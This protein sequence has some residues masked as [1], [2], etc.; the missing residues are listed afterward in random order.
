[1]NSRTAVGQVVLERAVADGEGARGTVN[2]AAQTGAAGRTVGTHGLVA[3]KYAV[4]EGH[5]P[6]LVVEAAAKGAACVGAAEG[7]II[8][9][10]AEGDGEGRARQV[11]NASAPAGG[12]DSL[13]H[14]A[15]QGILREGEVARVE[16]AG[17]IGGPTVGE[18]QTGDS[19][20][21][22]AANGKDSAGRVAADR[23]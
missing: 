11:L 15:N 9:E 7:L 4:V 12:G 10:E 3:D 20:V 19:H 22:P 17:P 23:Q 2:A 16:N 5:R 14:V 6:R 1:A 21:R 18:S 13:S 8:L